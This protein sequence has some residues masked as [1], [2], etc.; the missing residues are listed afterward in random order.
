MQAE[1]AER[2]GV[3]EAAVYEWEKRG[4][5]P[6]IRQ[7]PRVL[8]FLGYDPYPEPEATAEKLKAARRRRGWSQEELASCFGVDAGLLRE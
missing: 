7:W 1:A 6:S 8:A 5:A 3:S 4:R 2:M